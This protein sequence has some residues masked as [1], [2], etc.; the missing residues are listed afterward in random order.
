MIDAIVRE[1][2]TPK[3]LVLSL[4]SAPDVPQISVRQFTR[5]GELF[6]MDAA[7]VRVA[8]GR[9]VKSGILRSVARGQYTMGPGGERLLQTAR[10]W[11]CAEN[12]L[13]PWRGSWILVH[14]ANLGRSDR[15]ALRARERALRLE[16]MRPLRTE[17]WC[18]PANYREPLAETRQRLGDLGLEPEAPLLCVRELL[19]DSESDLAA[20]WQVRELERGYRNFRTA[21]EKSAARLDKMPLEKAARESFML[22]EAV[23]RQ[24]NA[25]PLLPDEFVDVQARRELIAAMQTYDEQGRR[26]WSAFRGN[27]T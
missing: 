2:P 8:I 17:L 6:G 5:W 24:I 18:R 7:A 12:R 16:G 11:R 1:T 15:S 25:D 10:G 3:R 19:P 22:G 14:T 20:L 23:I 26:I 9:L 27:D 21:L 13:A 4:L